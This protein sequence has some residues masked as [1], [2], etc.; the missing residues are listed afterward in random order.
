MYVDRVCSFCSLLAVAAERR[1]VS[2]S[3]LFNATLQ[4]VDD[5]D[6]SVER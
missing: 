1:F 4:T 6:S 2:R 3:D 5:I